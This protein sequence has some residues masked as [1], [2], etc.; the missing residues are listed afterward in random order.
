MVCRADKDGKVVILNYEGYNAIKM[1]EL[2][3]FEKM[4]VLISRCDLT[5]TKSE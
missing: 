1:K 4:D 5:L 2:Q 3:Q